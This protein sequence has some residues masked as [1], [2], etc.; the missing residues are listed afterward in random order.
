MME[1]QRIDRVSSGHAGKNWGN[2]TPVA[3]KLIVDIATNIYELS[4]VELIL[5]LKM[6]QS[7]LSTFVNPGLMRS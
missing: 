6:R 5:T 2:D 4:H 1:K 7:A 3:I